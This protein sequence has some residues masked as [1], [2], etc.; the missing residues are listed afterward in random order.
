METVAAVDRMAGVGMA[1]PWRGLAVILSAAFMTILDV[2]IVVVAAP[3]IRADLGTGAADIQL[4]LAAYNLAFGLTLVTGGR[5]GD[6]HGRRRIFRAGLLL[7]TASSLAASLAA[8]SRVLIAARAVQGLA[9]GLLM[10]QVFSIIQVG[11]DDEARGRAFGAF[12]FVS[13]VAATGAQLAGGALLA[14]DLFGLGWRAVFLVNVPVGLAALVASSRWVPESRAPA[15]H[16]QPLDPAGVLLL[17][18]ALALLVAPLTFGAERGWPA[19]TWACIAGSPVAL[20]AFF[21]WQRMRAQRGLAPLIAPTL[22]GKA[23]FVRGNL[24]ALAFYG[25]NAALFLALPL[26]VQ[27]GFGRSALASGL[28]FAPLALGFSVTA[29]CAGHLVARHGSRLVLLGSLLLLLGYAVLAAA[30]A[31]PAPDDD[32]RRLLPGVLLA[33]IGMGFVQ[34]GINYM[35]VQDVDGH[36]VGS[37]SGLLNTSFELG[38]ALGTIGAG[39][40]FLQPLAAGTP[41]PGALHAAFGRTLLLA[42]IL[43][44]VVALLARKATG[45][46]PTADARQN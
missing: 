3:A 36:E 31:L 46:A 4:V 43:V 9:A 6:L 33:G 29:A 42:S 17:T 35:S 41:H 24:M 28:L 16:R 27:E 14:L 10:P 13:G 22:F 19:W 8:G 7:F 12:A 39:I 30:V 2:F 5:L 21:R 26:L 15:G 44:L 40:V 11:F 34:P 20:W 18:G 38:Y 32:L 45:D 23:G 1:N 37:A 25:N